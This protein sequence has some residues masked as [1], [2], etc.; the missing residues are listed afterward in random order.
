MQRR[1]T[2]IQREECHL[3]NV[4]PHFRQPHS[5]SSETSHPG[6]GWA[7]RA[8]TA[9]GSVAK[10]F[11]GERAP[12]T[13]GCCSQAQRTAVV[14]DLRRHTHAG[15]REALRREAC[16]WAWHVWESPSPRAQPRLNKWVTDETGCPGSRRGRVVTEVPAPSRMCVC[17]SVCVCV[18]VCV[19][20]LRRNIVPFPYFLRVQITGD[21]LPSTALHH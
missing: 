4:R 12:R 13:N 6:T 7:H 18:C 3:L 16:P 19:C 21:K 2:P 11:A 10:A 14:S 8:E 15:S 5:R 1:R 20:G 9:G 17:V